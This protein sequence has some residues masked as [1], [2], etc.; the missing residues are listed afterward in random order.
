MCWHLIFLVPVCGSD[1]DEAAPHKEWVGLRGRSPG[2]TAL[3]F[4][5]ST[6]QFPTTATDVTLKK[7]YSATTPPLAFVLSPNQRVPGARLKC[8][9]ISHTRSY[10][11]ESRIH[12]GPAQPQERKGSSP[13]QADLDL[14]PNM[15]LHL[16]EKTH[17]FRSKVGLFTGVNRVNVC[18]VPGFCGKQ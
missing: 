11:G 6:R 8:K 4:W 7:S 18:L 2:P 5:I 10:N 12:S 13:G 9:F 15:A 1:M 14:G 17:F 16:L 3:C